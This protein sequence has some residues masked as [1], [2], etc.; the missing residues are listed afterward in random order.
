MEF[1]SE[2]SNYGILSVLVFL[3]K[4]TTLSKNHR[5]RWL[6]LCV[7]LFPAFIQIFVVKKS[8]FISVSSAFY[9]KYIVTNNFCV[10]THN[11]YCSLVYCK[12]HIL[13]IG[14][15]FDQ[16][17][18]RVGNF[19]FTCQIID[20]LYTLHKYRFYS[21][22]FSSTGEVFNQLDQSVHH[23][24]KWKGA[25]KMPSVAKKRLLRKKIKRHYLCSNQKLASTQT[26]GSAF[27]ERV[28][29]LQNSKY[30]HDL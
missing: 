9:E 3:C 23:N 27:L 2:I 6:Q 12:F 5:S 30:E 17:L 26:I 22:G 11:S 19:Y 16:I 25:E 4:S 13:L 10:S 24:M 29:K 15:S 14:S 28:R 7:K 20:C 18:Q 1:L 21:N 8:L